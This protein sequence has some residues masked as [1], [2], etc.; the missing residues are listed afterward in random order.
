[1]NSSKKDENMAQVFLESCSL[2]VERYSK[3]EKNN[4]TLD[5]KVST[6]DGGMFLCEVKSIFTKTGERG[7]LHKTI[8]NNLSDKVHTAFKQFKSVNSRHLVPNVLIFISHNYQINRH[9]FSQL[10]NGAIIIDEL[11]VKDLGKYRFGRIK[12]EIGKIDLYIWLED[13]DVAHYFLNPV[14]RLFAQKLSGI[15]NLSELL[16]NP[17]ST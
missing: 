5:F 9:T 10:I 4:D 1:M 14:D 8:F 16:A 6:S 7:L 13:Q 12:K 2:I 11:L 17:Q 15:F 3:S